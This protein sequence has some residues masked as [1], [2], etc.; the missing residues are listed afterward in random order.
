M[1]AWIWRGKPSRTGATLENAEGLGNR[2]LRLGSAV[3]VQAGIGQAH[4]RTALRTAQGFKR[5]FRL[6]L[7]PL[8]RYFRR[9]QE[10]PAGPG[11][12]V[13]MRAALRGGRLRRGRTVACGWRSRGAR[14]ASHAR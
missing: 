14:E 7:R 4:L 13:Q 5:V 9:A 2:P 3:L 1:P 6:P 8:P 10:H 12:V 11:R